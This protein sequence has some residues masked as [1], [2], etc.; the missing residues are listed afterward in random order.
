MIR[1]SAALAMLTLLA[2]CGA[3]GDPIRPSLNST[4]SV[5][6]SGVSLGTSLGV[7][8]GPVSLAVAL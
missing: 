5:T 6:P 1:I 3:D 4:L 8:K 2:A 7:S